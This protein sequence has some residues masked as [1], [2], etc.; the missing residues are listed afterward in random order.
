MPLLKK[1]FNS[2]VVHFRYIA[3]GSKS[4]RVLLHDVRTCKLLSEVSPS[5]PFTRSSGAFQL[6]R[7]PRII[8][9]IDF[10]EDARRVVSCGNDGDVAL[11]DISVSHTSVPHS[12]DL[13]Y[14][15]RLHQRPDLFLL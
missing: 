4:G 6:R 8:Q 10:S 14:S 1:V 9:A 13:A 3:S 15:Y 2:R 11:T 12:L 5:I 7:S